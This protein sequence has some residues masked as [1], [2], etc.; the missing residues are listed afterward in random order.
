MLNGYVWQSVK[1]D[2]IASPI[3]FMY[4]VLCNLD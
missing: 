1:A 3:V 2:Q 4:D